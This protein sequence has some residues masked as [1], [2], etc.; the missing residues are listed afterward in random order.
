MT[1]FSHLVD[2]PAPVEVYDAIHAELLRRTAGRVP[3]LIV[4]LCQPTDG[5]FQVVEIWASQADY[6]QAERELIAPS[7]LPRPTNGQRA[8]PD[9]HRADRGDPPPRPRHPRSNPVA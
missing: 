6:Q 9:H 2:V 8:R 5:G 1:Y 3:G 4:H 7:R